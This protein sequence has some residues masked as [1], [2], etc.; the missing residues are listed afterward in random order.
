MEQ[1]TPTVPPK[2]RTWCYVTGAVLGLGVAPAL[3]AFGLTEA[4]GAA[5]ALAGAA[6]ALAVGYRPT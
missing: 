4:A 1:E 2:V 3:L 5:A 6:N